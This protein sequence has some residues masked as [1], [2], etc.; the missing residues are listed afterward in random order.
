MIFAT[1]ARKRFYNTVEQNM[2]IPWNY[3]GVGAVVIWGMYLE[4]RR[5]K[6]PG[7]RAHEWI[8]RTHTEEELRALGGARWHMEDDEQEKYDSI[9]AEKLG[10]VVEKYIANASRKA[11][12]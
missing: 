6:R 5:T 11:G 7:E 2:G 10:A 8:V 1:I 12:Y 9:R 4:Y 3:I